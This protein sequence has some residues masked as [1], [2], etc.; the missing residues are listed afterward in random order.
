[1]FSGVEKLTR[2]GDDVENVVLLDFRGVGG[3]VPRGLEVEM[4]AERDEEDD[5]DAT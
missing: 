1:M 5:K 2:T 4:E 3:C